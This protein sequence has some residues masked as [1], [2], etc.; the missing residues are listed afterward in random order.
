MLAAIERAFGKNCVAAQPANSAVLISLCWD[1]GW[2][3]IG[4]K[5]NEQSPVYQP[6]YI[7]TADD[8]YTRIY[9]SCMNLKR[10]LHQIGT[11]KG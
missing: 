6:A 8:G 10:T 5:R 7:G 9:Y 11:L 3:S 1:R 2:D 4:E